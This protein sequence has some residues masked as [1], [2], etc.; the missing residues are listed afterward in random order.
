M[1]IRKVEGALGKILDGLI[2]YTANHFMAEETLMMKCNYPGYLA[3][4]KE[5]ASLAATVL[6]LQKKIKSSQFALSVETIH[7]L[8][9]WLAG[10]IMGTDKQYAPFL[11]KAAEK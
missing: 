10:H 3:H 1:Q 6:E 8:R 7:F 4:K 11:S 9:D 5:H 2:E